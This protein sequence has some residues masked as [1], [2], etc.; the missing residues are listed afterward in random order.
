MASDAAGGIPA[1]AEDEP[2]SAKEA[3]RALKENTNA[4]PVETV[5]VETVAPGERSRCS[6]SWLGQLAAA[7][8]GSQPTPEVPFFFS[9][10]SSFCFVTLCIAVL[11]GVVFGAPSGLIVGATAL[12]AFPLLLPSLTTALLH[13]LGAVALEVPVLLALVALIGA[14]RD[15]HRGPTARDHRP[16]RIARPLVDVCLLYTSPSPRD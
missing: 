5:V 8:P 15:R 14:S 13:L 6:R 7:V 1:A 10:R 16:R 2:T 9:S 3:P 11:R 12:L 4:A